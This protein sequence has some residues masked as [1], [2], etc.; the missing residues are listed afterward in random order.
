MCSSCNTSNLVKFDKAIGLLRA[1]D[2][3]IPIGVI[4]TFLA[5]SKHEEIVVG[6]LVNQVDLGTTALNRALTYLG[7]EHW[8][9][10][11]PGLGLVD[12]VVNPMDRRSRIASLSP[13]G[14]KLAEAMETV[15]T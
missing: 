6:E 10:N 13:K 14:R 15:L 4:V 5:L 7:S 12:Q 11:K 8:S 1:H 9:K 3:N 2:P